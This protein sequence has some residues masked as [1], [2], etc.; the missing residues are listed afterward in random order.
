MAVRVRLSDEELEQVE[1][2]AGV[3]YS[4][5]QIAMYLDVPKKDFL[6]DFYDLTSLIYYHYQRGLL[7][8]DANAGMALAK[9]AEAGNITAHQQ[10]E[11]IRRKQLVER[12]RKRIIYGQETA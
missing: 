3:G 4:A 7:L 10:L 9:N 6:L 8:T 5:E 1:Q 12:E 11:K 2:L